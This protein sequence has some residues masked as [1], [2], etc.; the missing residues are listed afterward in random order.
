MGVE[1]ALLKAG[2]KAKI[3]RNG[4]SVMIEYTGW[5]FDETAVNKKGVQFDTSKERK[6]FET[7]IGTGKVIKGSHASSQPTTPIGNFKITQM[8]AAG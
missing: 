2:D 7:E 5:L 1:K 3:P 6:D 8:H 4:D